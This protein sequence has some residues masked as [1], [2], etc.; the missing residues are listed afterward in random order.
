M[1]MKPVINKRRRYRKQAEICDLPRQFH[2]QPLAPDLIFLH[3]GFAGFQ[4][5]QRRVLVFQSLA[6]AG[7]AVQLVDVH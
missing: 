4:P 6:P 2:C 7:L 1:R 5:D 3:A